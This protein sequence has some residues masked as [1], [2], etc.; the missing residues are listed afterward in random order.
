ML[1]RSAVREGLSVRSADGVRVGEVVCLEDDEVVIEC[2]PHDEERRRVLVPL[3]HVVSVERDALHL[4]VS[5]KDMAKFDEAPESLSGD[6]PGTSDVVK[7]AL[8]INPSSHRR[9]DKDRYEERVIGVSA[10]GGEVEQRVTSRPMQLGGA[11]E[12]RR[13]RYVPEPIDESRP[14]EGSDEDRDDDR[15]QP[16]RADQAEHP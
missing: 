7:E 13:T 4:S 1:D 12:Q 2:A 5:S 3:R 10:D 14:M 15:E 6:A 11:H 8:H 9:R 16:I